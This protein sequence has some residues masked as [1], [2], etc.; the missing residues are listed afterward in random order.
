MQSH[1]F[2]SPYILIGSGIIREI[3]SEV[4]SEILTLVKGNLR[5]GMAL[6]VYGLMEGRVRYIIGDG[7]G[8]R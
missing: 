4:K 5:I 1:F 3:P 2:K 6:V 7:R 8:S